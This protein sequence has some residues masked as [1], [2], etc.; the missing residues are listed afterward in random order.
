MMPIGKTA[1][2]E[3]PHQ[4][5]RLEIAPLKL[6]ALFRAIRARDDNLI[7]EMI[8][9]RQSHSQHRRELPDP[10]RSILAGLSPEL[11]F[12]HVGLR[13]P[14]LDPEQSLI[15]TCWQPRQTPLLPACAQ[16]AVLHQVDHQGRDHRHRDGHG[17][18]ETTMQLEST[19]SQDLGRE[20]EAEVRGFFAEHARDKVGPVEGGQRRR[21][22]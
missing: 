6:S 3:L 4:R 17:Q 1:D 21:V 18:Y 7:L 22:E 10:D 20:E 11:Q 5:A 19:V 9:F 14:Q 13:P 2:V 16:L 8:K 15:V 12:N